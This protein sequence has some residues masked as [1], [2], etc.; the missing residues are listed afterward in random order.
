MHRYTDSRGR[1]I[2]LYIV[3]SQSN[4]RAT[5]PP[6]VF[7]KGSGVSI[8]DKGKKSIIIASSNLAFKVNWL[9]LDNN[10]NQQM[11]YYWYKTGGVFTHSYWKQRAWAVYNNIIGKSTGNALIRIS[12]DI[13]NGHQAEA[14]NFLNKFA[15]I[16]IPQLYLHLP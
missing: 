7:Y 9:I 5:N 14:I 15:C 13:V 12:T 8:I 3:Y 1:H 4:P 6:E 10:E 16:L 11:A 2:Y